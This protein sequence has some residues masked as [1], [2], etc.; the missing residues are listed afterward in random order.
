MIISFKKNF[1][2]DGGK[3]IEMQNTEMR[4]QKNKELDEQ[5]ENL[6]F[7]SRKIINFQRSL[8]N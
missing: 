5:K 2:T 8:T 7:L 4:E 1:L 6:D 3:L